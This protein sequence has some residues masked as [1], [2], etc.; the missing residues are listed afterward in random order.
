M[1]FNFNLNDIKIIYQIRAFLSG[2][3]YKLLFH[4]SR[5]SKSMSP[6][7]ILGSHLMFTIR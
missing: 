1:T 6:Q 2:E 5:L 3:V 7:L 4:M